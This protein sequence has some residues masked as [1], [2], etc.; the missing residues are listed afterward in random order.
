MIMFK[1]KRKEKKKRGRIYIKG[2]D[3]LKKVIEKGIGI[4]KFKFWSGKK[5]EKYGKGIGKEINEG[6]KDVEEKEWEDENIEI[7]GIGIELKY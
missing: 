2:K 7:E 1:M 5:G 3:E 6:E 4:E